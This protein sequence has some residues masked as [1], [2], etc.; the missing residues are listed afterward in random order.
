M[1]L[2][3]K[4]IEQVGSYFLRRGNTSFRN[5]KAPWEFGYQPKEPMQAT[6][7]TADETVGAAGS[8]GPISSPTQFGTT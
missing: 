7:G 4:R 3:T 1:P 6:S 5:Q 8:T 2:P